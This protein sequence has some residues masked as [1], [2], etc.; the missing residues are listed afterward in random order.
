M[1]RK[2]RPWKIIVFLILALLFFVGCLTLVLNRMTAEAAVGRILTAGDS[3]PAAGAD[4]VLVLGCGVERDGSPTPMLAD[5][6]RAGID[7]YGSGSTAFLL[8]S[9][10]GRSPDYDEVTPMRE[11]ALNAG[12]GADRVL[13][14]PMGLSTS[15]SILRARDEFGFR[16]VIIVTQ[17]YHLDRALYLARSLG[18]EAWGYPAE[19]IRYTGQFFRDVREIIARCKDVLF[20]ETGIFP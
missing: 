13:S 12:I 15:Q 6:I 7:A 16:R 4:A 5:R 3:S 2:K 19:D 20:C 9:G 8:M 11:A 10:D 14:D 18:M 17:R 1:Y